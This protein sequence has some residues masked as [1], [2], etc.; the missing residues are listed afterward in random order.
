M[1]LQSS[2]HASRIAPRKKNISKKA[3]LLSSPPCSAF[4]PQTR[5]A[6]IYV[7]TYL[8]TAAGAILRANIEERRRVRVCFSE[9]A[10]RRL[11]PLL[12]GL[13]LKAKRFVRRQRRTPRVRKTHLKA[14]HLAALYIPKR[15]SPLLC[16]ISPAR[17]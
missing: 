1:L 12:L 14:L 11:S 3:P 9:R 2:F 17:S 8:E 4:C 6:D 15:L 13:I 5:R 7:C 10:I 16:E